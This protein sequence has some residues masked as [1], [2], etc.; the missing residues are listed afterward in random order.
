[1]RDCPRPGREKTIW[2]ELQ[3]QLDSKGIRIRKGI[4]QDGTFT[5]KN[6]KTFFGYKGH[7]LT[8]L[9]SVPIIR[10]YAVTTASTHDSRIDLSK[11]G[12]PVYR[13]KGYF[14]V[15]PKGYDA[16][17]AKAI[18]NFKLSLR[19]IMRNGR[20]SRKRAL[21]ESPFATLKRMFHFSHTLVTLSRRVRVKFMFACFAYNLHVVKILQG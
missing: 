4:L 18:V 1:M 12:I 9:N 5:K 2:N 7:I 21:V 15:K 11:N 17:M 13:D 14:G 10:S 16:T 6:N 19:S 20:I 8:D 3:R